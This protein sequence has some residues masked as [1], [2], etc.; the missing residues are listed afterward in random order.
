MFLEVL[1]AGAAVAY[2]VFALW[3]MEWALTAFPLLIPFYLVKATFFGIPFTLPEVVIYA[4]VAAALVD[5]AKN[6]LM[7]S[8][9]F[10]SVFGSMSSVVLRRESFLK[11]YG[12]LLLP[13]AVFVLGAF[14]ALVAVEGKIVFFD[15]QVFEGMRTALGILKGWIIAPVLFLIVYLARIPNN[16]RLLDTL[17]VYGFSAVALAVWALFQV[18]TDGYVTPDARASGPF[19]SANY[20]ALYIVPALI[21]MM[22]RIKDIVLPLR[23]EEKKSFIGSFFGRGD[24]KEKHPEISLF[25][26]AFLL[27]FLALLASKSYTGM[28]AAMG[29]ALFYFGLEFLEFKSRNEQSLNPWKFLAG[30]LFFTVVMIGV[31]Y[32]IDPGKWQA[33]FR[34]DE[35]NSSSVRM[36]VYTV[37]AGLIGENWL[38]GIGPG[39]YEAMYKLHAERLLGREPYELNMLHPHNLFFAVWLNTGILGFL[40]FVAILVIA[41]KRCAF[42][43]KKFVSSKINSAPKLRVLGT[44]ILTGILIYGLFDTPFFKND[45]SILFW[46]VIAIIFAADHEEKSST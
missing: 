5:F 12:D 39:Q 28:I 30:F 26:L 1:F 18:S 35:R 21:Y 31:I 23:A 11:K 44:A 25:I 9:I 43:F 40:G 22:I 33:M 2:F 13:L 37:S 27:L 7:P 45:L 6:N 16:N 19:E 41:F 14:V 10:S 15:G 17:N 38:T 20:L 34:F 32:V 3:R 24:I 42:N 46:I 29:G 4:L 36:E 8:S